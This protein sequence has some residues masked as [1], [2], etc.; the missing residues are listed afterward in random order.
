MYG[1]KPDEVHP[2]WKVERIAQQYEQELKLQI[3]MGMGAEATNVSEPNHGSST[4]ETLLARHAELPQWD[5][6]S[7]LIETEL[8]VLPVDAAREASYKLR[9]PLFD[10]AIAEL[11]SKPSHP[12]VDIL[13]AGDKVGNYCIV[14]MIGHGAVANVYK[15]RNETG[16][17]VAIKLLRSDWRTAGGIDHEQRFQM[18]SNF[19]R[20]LRHSSIVPFLESGEHAGLPYHVFRYIEGVTLRDF[21]RDKILSP[22]QAA[23][24]VAQ[25]ADAIHHSHRQGIVHR[26]LKPSNILLAKD[27]RVFVTDFGSALGLHHEVPHA[28]FVGTPMYMSPEQARGMSHRLDGRADVFALGVILY[29]LTTGTHPF[30]SGDAPLDELLHGVESVAAPPLRQ[31]VNVPIEFEQICLKSLSR[32]PADRHQTSEDLARALRRFI[33]AA[34]Y[35]RLR[36][37]FA[38]AL[39]LMVMVGVWSLSPKQIW[40]SRTIGLGEKRWGNDR[41]MEVDSHA[42]TAV[43]T[44]GTT[45]QP[46]VSAVSPVGL[47]PND[48]AEASEVEIETAAA[49][50]L[51][52]LKTEDEIASWVWDYFKGGRDNTLQAILI[53]RCAQAEVSLAILAQQFYTTTSSDLRFALLLAMGQYAPD[54]IDSTERESLIATLLELYT[55]DADSGIHSASRWLLNRWGAA[56]QADQQRRWLQSLPPAADQ[57]W[58]ELFDNLTMIHLP[59]GVSQANSKSTVAI[60]AYEISQSQ[61]NRYSGGATDAEGD[62]VPNLPKSDVTWQMV[63][64]FC[65]RLSRLAGLAESEMCY[66]VIG[67]TSEAPLYAEHADIHRRIGFRMPTVEEWTAAC[68]AGSETRRFWG[69]MEALNHC[70]ANYRRKGSRYWK[71]THIGLV[72]PNRWGLFDTLGNVSEWMH[73]RAPS[74]GQSDSAFEDAMREIRGGS[75]WTASNGLNVDSEYSMS[76]QSQFDRVGFRIARTITPTVQSVP[77]LVVS[78]SSN[79]KDNPLQQ[80]TLFDPSHVANYSLG[81]I[82]RGPDSVHAIV[83]KNNYPKPLSVTRVTLDGASVAL[84]D[85]S[86]VDPTAPI[87]LEPGESRSIPWRLSQES[88]G[89]RLIRGSIDWEFEEQ[90]LLRNDLVVAV[91][92]VGPVL[93]LNTLTTDRS[94]FAVFDIGTLPPG[95]V[96]RHPLVLRNWGDQPMKIA[97]ASIEPPFR[98]ESQ[99]PANILHEL[100]FASIEV[101]IDTSRAGEFLSRLRLQT[102]DPITP[103]ITIEY[104]ARISQLRSVPV[105]GVYRSGLWLLDTNR[106]GQADHSFSFGSEKAKPLIGDFDGDGMQEFAIYLPSQDNKLQIVIRK[107]LLNTDVSEITRTLNSSMESIS[108]VIA[109]DIDRDGR[110]DLGAVTKAGNETKIHFECTGDDQYDRTIVIDRP[111]DEVLIHDWNGDGEPEQIRVAVNNQGPLLNWD[112]TTIKWRSLVSTSVWT[113]G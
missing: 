69:R 2:A 78:L 9:F 112:V 29:E 109:V 85:A 45:P 50:V 5:L 34:R 1:G 90:S 19:A 39:V 63:A 47:L 64:A 92:T 53:D 61:W 89:Y 68:R 86:S 65:N 8:D 21:A 17:L 80:Q 35:S 38:T 108:Q 95:S 56:A 54:Q 98:V 70:Y 4:I 100:E 51:Q 107:S 96:F 99:R 57:Q 106:D 27:G 48:V 103:N 88:A 81:R 77:G 101:G 3:K 11:L 41:F 20:K 52:H 30:G 67:G 25:V 76:D 87:A 12:V 13:Q 15:A 60:S 44:N 93:A 16:T 74:T 28:S 104:R 79:E 42:S 23:R 40:S 113:I 31:R 105:C 43:T 110:S 59:N 37:A 73:Q 24:I 97:E 102:S 62:Q 14:D 32:D 91:Y 71:P 10:A 7:A 111:C 72:K 82:P 83:V 36:T 84:S 75:A 49:A 55:R 26:D 66:Q 6:L 94:G 18:E 46:T 22:I 58:S 33:F